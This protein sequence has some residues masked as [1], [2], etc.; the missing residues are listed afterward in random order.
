MRKLLHRIYSNRYFLLFIL[1]F[2]YA[3]SIYI[4][5]NIWNEFNAYIFTPE[6]ALAKLIDVIIL[7]LLILFFIRRWQKL[8]VFETK[9]ML[10]IFS[11][12]I[13]S[14][15]LVMLIIELVI[16]FAFGNIQRNFNKETLL[17]TTFSKFL[18]A[19]I[20]GSFFLVYY[21]YL[22]NK[23][24]LEQ[25][26]TYHKA[27]SESR[28]SQLKAQ[29]N[30]HFLFNNLNILDQLIEEDKHKA[31]EFLNEFADIYRYVLQATDKKLVPIKEELAFAEQYFKIIKHKYG[32]AYQ[33]SFDKRNLNGFIS[34]LTLQLL[35]ENAVQHNLGT[36]KQPITI[37]ITIN[38]NL[39]VSNNRIS[40]RYVKQTS[41][42]SLINL[43][44]QYRLLANQPI[45]TQASESIFSVNIP[46]INKVE[47]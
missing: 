39:C 37:H 20:Y 6:A 27:I 19:I 35:I 1:L 4:R 38:Q 36:E 47:Q 5:G 46:I 34:P 45:E 12:S 17:F 29:L 21:Y 26:T 2:A 24:Y 15:I 18:D 10:K 33:L 8:E 9:E 23:K 14:Y 7:F 31:S 44:E 41:G 13:V 22:K 42:R 40:K 25:L 11:A 16:A 3:Q 32:D 28:I 43:K 30:P